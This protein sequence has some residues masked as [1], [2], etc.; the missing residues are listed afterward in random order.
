MLVP[1]STIVM[2]DLIDLHKSKLKHND[3]YVGEFVNRNISSTYS[4]F[5]P[6][7]KLMGCRKESKTMEEY[8]NFMQINISKDHSS[9]LEFQGNL[10]KFLYGLSK[11]RKMWISLWKINRNKN[12]RRYVIL[13]EDW[14]QETPIKICLCSLMCIC[15]PS[16]EL[17]K[18]AKYGWFNKLNKKQLL[19]SN[20]EVSKYLINSLGK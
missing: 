12:K 18:R 4:R 7:N 2:K 13:P 14:L 15:L 10:N 3:M 11:T 16:L 17:L 6:S 19:E 20:M 9:E 8:I 1:N 5:F